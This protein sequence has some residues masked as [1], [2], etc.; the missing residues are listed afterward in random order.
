M[1]SP[2]AVAALKAHLL[3]HSYTENLDSLEKVEEFLKKCYPSLR[4]ETVYGS[5]GSRG[6]VIVSC[7]RFYVLPGSRCGPVQPAR[8]VFFGDGTYSFQVIYHSLVRDS[9]RSSQA[10]HVTITNLIDTLMSDSGHVLCPGIVDYEDKFKDLLKN[11]N[12]KLRS[13]TLP[14]QRYDSVSCQMWHKP[15]NSRLPS[16]SPLIDLCKECRP[17]YQDMRILRTRA[18]TVYTFG[19]AESDVSTP[20]QCGSPSR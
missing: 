8:M 6:W 20:L 9:W 14:I 10:P 12:K 17:L 2:A 16:D 1:A 11:E 5:E 18:L 15:S 4:S 19:P 7:A 3:K 13:W